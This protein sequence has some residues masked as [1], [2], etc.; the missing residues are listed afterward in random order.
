ML[1]PVKSYLIGKCF[2]ERI[3]GRL[4]GAY[5]ITH[6]FTRQATNVR[7]LVVQDLQTK[8]LRIVGKTSMLRAIAD[9]RMMMGY[10]WFI[11]GLCYGAGKNKRGDDCARCDGVATIWIDTGY[12]KDDVI[13]FRLQRRGKKDPI[14]K[15][16]MLFPK[17]NPSKHP[18]QTAKKQP[19]IPSKTVLE[20]W[21]QRRDRARE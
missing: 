7:F 10:T 11:C 20:N 4:G 15:A 19:E 12:T 18:K 14:V 9:K 8:R 21:I 16:S 17:K 1:I 13:N 2:R 5:L 3:R 6:Y